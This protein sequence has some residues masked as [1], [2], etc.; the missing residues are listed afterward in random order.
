ML[1][2]S[3]SDLIKMVN[4]SPTKCLANRRSNEIAHVFMSEECRNEI[5]HPPTTITHRIFV[6]FSIEFP[7]RLAHV[8]KRIVDES[9]CSNSDAGDEGIA[10]ATG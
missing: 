5:V 6:S 1:E 8:S 9:S 2:D 3:A 4:I 10:I 7:L